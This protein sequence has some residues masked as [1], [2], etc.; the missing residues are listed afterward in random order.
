VNFSICEVK[1]YANIG[2]CLG[3][4]IMFPQPHHIIAN[5]IIIATLWKYITHRFSALLGQ[6]YYA[7]LLVLNP[8]NNR[9]FWVKSL[10]GLT[11]E[12]GQINFY[13]YRS[14]F[15]VTLGGG[16]PVSSR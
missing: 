5:I 2:V 8:Q 3:T 16:P 7:L 10:L 1:P 4:A 12:Q 11:L 9:T 15:Q 6:A 13:L 14:H